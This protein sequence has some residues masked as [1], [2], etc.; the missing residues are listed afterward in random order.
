M[1]SI[2]RTKVFIP[3]LLLANCSG[4]EHS[5]HEAKISTVDSIAPDSNVSAPK[6]NNY[7]HDTLKV[8]GKAVVFFSISQEEYDSIPE[9]DD[10][11]L[12]EVLS[13]FNFYAGEVADTLR[14]LGFE[15]MIT[16]SR[17]IQLKLDNGESRTFDR[18]NNAEHIVG[19]IFTDGVKEPLVEYGVSTDVDIIS[20]FDAFIKN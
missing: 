9:D 8:S 20:S 14:S 3:I 17:F 13:D 12:D 15:T 5:R 11:G 10:S 7:Y 4:R 19:Y 6:E 2:V 16:G 18:F 1:N